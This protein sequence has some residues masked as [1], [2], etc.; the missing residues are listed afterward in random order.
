MPLLRNGGV[1]DDAW[2][3]LGGRSPE[4]VAP[5]E[6]LLAPLAAWRDQRAA[7]LARAAPLGVALAPA[8]AVAEIAGDLDRLALVV[9]SFPKHTDGRAF[10]QARLLRER[11]G[12]R[13]EIRATGHVLRDQFLFLQRCGVD[14]VTVDDPA[15]LGPW[16]AARALFPGH[17]QP[18]LDPAG[19]APGRHAAEACAG[20]GR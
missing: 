10:S 19:P 9:L 16:N 11:H 15:L 4:E 12:F 14:S 7:L 18:A 20:R 13:G 17:Y 1:E 8:D 5:D 2:T 3:T 6:A